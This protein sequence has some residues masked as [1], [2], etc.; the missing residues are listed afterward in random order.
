MKKI[1]TLIFT[2]ILINPTFSN[3]NNTPEVFKK[4]SFGL[5]WQRISETGFNSKD[6][7]YEYRAIY[8]S[9]NINKSFSVSLNIQNV[10][11]KSYKNTSIMEEISY[12]P[13]KIT[14]TNSVSF[15]PN[16]TVGILFPCS[17]YRKYEQFTGNVTL[18]YFP[19]K[20]YF[21]VSSGIARLT[22][23]RENGHVS[24]IYGYPG[25][26]DTSLAYTAERNNT[27]FGL[28]NIGIKLQRKNGLFLKFDIIKL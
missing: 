10:N 11:A 13:T 18:D 19:F 9:Y 1:I 22:N 27:I 8:A 2:M 12:L 3:E 16:G 26:P 21:F 28:L 4:Y 6:M 7:I 24:E 14:C 5:G 25:S 17:V 23:I 15:Y 20:N